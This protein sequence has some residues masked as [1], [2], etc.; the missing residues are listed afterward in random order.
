MKMK[1]AI[2]T[3]AALLMTAG[4]SYAAPAKYS[5]Y[6]WGHKQSYNSH[7]GVSPSERAAIARSA[8]NVA[9]VKRRALRDGRITFVERFLI[10]GAERRH[11]ALVSRAYRS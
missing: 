3:V 1:T 11:A 5:H 2:L 4:A 6:N 8:A 7:R 9:A 10:N